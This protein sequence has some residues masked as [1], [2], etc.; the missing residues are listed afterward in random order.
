MNFIN[1]H[2]I[3]FLLQRVEKYNLE[4]SIMFDKINLEDF[5]DDNFETCIEILQNQENFEYD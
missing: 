5:W 1:Q 3:I 4:D 2:G